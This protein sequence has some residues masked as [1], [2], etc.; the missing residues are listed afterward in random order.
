MRVHGVLSSRI[1]AVALGKPPSG[2]VR[3]IG[4]TTCTQNLNQPPSAELLNYAR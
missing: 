3:G 4:A 2:R 1:P